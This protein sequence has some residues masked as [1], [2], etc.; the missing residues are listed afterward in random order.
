MT[1][2]ERAAFLFNTVVQTGYKG[3]QSEAVS[4]VKEW[5]RKIGA[6]D[7]VVTP[8]TDDTTSPLTGVPNDGKEG[9]KGKS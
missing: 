8:K 2:E 4:D 1:D 7:L 3:E 6:G 5:L 9:T